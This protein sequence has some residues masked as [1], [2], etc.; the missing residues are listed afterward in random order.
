VVIV[1]II[2]TI[3]ATVLSIAPSPTF[4]PPKHPTKIKITEINPKRLNSA[5]FIKSD[6]ETVLFAI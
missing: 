4:S 1:G 6:C 3:N 2:T 5:F